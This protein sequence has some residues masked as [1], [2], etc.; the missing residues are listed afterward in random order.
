MN[1]ISGKTC[2]NVLGTALTKANIPTTEGIYQRETKTIYWKSF[3]ALVETDVIPLNNAKC[4]HIWDSGVA[5]CGDK[6]WH[7]LSPIGL[8]FSCDLSQ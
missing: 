8:S 2:L 5:F 3:L 7:C 4:C 1:L 6:S